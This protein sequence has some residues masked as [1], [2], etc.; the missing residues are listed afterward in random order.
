MSHPVAPSGPTKTISASTSS[1][2]VALQGKSGLTGGLYEIKNPTAAVAYV[3]WGAGSAPT[4]AATDYPVLP[5]EVAVVEPP[6][7]S[8]YVAVLL[9]TGTGNVHFTPSSVPALG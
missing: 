5:G 6:F 9:S 2:N 3:K 4:A 1:A 7:D 8:D